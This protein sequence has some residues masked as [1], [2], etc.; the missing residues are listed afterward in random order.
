MPRVTVTITMTTPEARR[1]CPARCLEGRTRQQPGPA[2]R[3]VA[4]PTRP[5]MWRAV[6]ARLRA[7]FTQERPR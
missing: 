5:A 6:L 3:P 4:R 7:V 2:P 1:A